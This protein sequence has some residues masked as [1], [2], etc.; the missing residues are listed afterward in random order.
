MA[1]VSVLQRLK[2]QKMIQLALDPDIEFPSF[3]DAPPGRDKSFEYPRGS[4]LIKAECLVPLAFVFDEMGKRWLYMRYE[5]KLSLR[6]IAKK[7]RCDHKA[8]ERRIQSV[9]D[10]AV[11]RIQDK[12]A[13]FI[14]AVYFTHFQNVKPEDIEISP[15]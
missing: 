5:E 9:L 1:D 13:Y 4:A 8:V 3:V 15:P 7:Y 12:T 6:D 2:I 11:D 14:L 10:D